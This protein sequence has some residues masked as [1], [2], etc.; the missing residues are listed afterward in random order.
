MNCCCFLIFTGLILTVRS[1]VIDNVFKLVKN[2]NTKALKLLIEDNKDSVATFIN[3]RQAGSGQTPLMMA[4]LMGHDTVVNLLLSMKEVDASIAEK[5]GYTPF[6][7]AGFQGRR[8][9]ARLLLKDQRS[10]DPSARHSDSFTP[11]HRACWGNEKRHRDTVAV[12]VEEAGV[13]WDEKTGTGQTC[14][15]ITKN[16]KT[17]KWLKLWAKNH[18]GE[19]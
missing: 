5:D 2:G 6:H 1:A 9:I 12:L 19:L 18:S 15:D 16:V 4:V 17:K 8:D 10:L 14:M 3:V 13:P 7:G 11:L